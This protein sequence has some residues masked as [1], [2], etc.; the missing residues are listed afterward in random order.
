MTDDEVQIAR[1]KWSIIGRWQSD[2]GYFVMTRFPAHREE[3]AHN[4]A[5]QVSPK[6]HAI[7]V[8]TA[9]EKTTLM[10]LN[11]GDGGDNNAYFQGQEKLL[12][13]TEIL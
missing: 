7:V 8:D 3:D 1:S 10:L 5:K 11:D 9:T 12:T 2:K 13:S 4:Y 6:W